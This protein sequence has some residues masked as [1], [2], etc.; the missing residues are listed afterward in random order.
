VARPVAPTEAL[1]GLPGSLPRNVPDL[2]RLRKPP[3]QGLI[4]AHIGMELLRGMRCGG[5]FRR[6]EDGVSLIRFM[7]TRGPNGKPTMKEEKRAACLR[8]DCD[9]AP[10]MQA[11]AVAVSLIEYRWLVD[12]PDPDGTRARKIATG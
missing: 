11:G 8:D 9:Y 3:E 5:C 2:G 4:E 10:K 7:P 1:P 12:D 6:I